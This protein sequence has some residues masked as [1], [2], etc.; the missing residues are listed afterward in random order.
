MS[1]RFSSSSSSSRQ[2]DDDRHLFIEY[3]INPAC[4]LSTF[5]SVTSTT[6]ISRLLWPAHHLQMA[7]TLKKER[8]FVGPTKL[9]DAILEGGC[10]IIWFLSL[11]F[12]YNNWLLFVLGPRAPRPAYQKIGR[13]HI[14]GPEKAF[15]VRSKKDRRRRR[16]ANQLSIGA[17]WGDD[18]EENRSCWRKKE[19]TPAPTY[20]ELLWCCGSAGNGVERE[21]DDIPSGNEA[22]RR[23]LPFLISVLVL[24]ASH[25][26]PHPHTDVYCTVCIYSYLVIIRVRR[27]ANFLRARAR[28][29][30]SQRGRSFSFLSRANQFYEGNKSPH[31]VA[32]LLFRNIMEL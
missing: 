28:A 12:L 18:G 19:S 27:R 30:G 22:Q 26:I 6:V 4:V 15:A 17:K 24:L 8:T 14:S 11:Y 23:F 5:R 13:K 21:R 29:P 1:L 32:S 25:V 3:S 10:A 7:P 9:R 31:R 16:R 20:S 2:K